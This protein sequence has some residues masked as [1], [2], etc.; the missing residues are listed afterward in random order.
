MCNWKVFSFLSD[1]LPGKSIGKL[2]R[3]WEGSRVWTQSRSQKWPQ[4]IRLR[5]L[6]QEQQ[7][8]ATEQCKWT[9]WS[10]CPSEKLWGKPVWR[11]RLMRR[12][13]GHI[14]DA[15]DDKLPELQQGCECPQGLKGNTKGQP[16]TDRQTNFTNSGLNTSPG[17]F[18]TI[19]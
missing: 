4:P 1:T 11:G 17:A 16:E 7:R 5:K 6:I 10:W 18:L 3:Q 13:R 8:S 15:A 19:R 12:A 2:H 14:E 9:I